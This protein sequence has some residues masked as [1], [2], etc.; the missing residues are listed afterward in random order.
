MLIGKNFS[1]PDQ[2]QERT[3]G[4]RIV[5]DIAD[6]LLAQDGDIS[7]L[8]DSIPTAVEYLWAHGRHE[9]RSG[10]ANATRNACNYLKPNGWSRT[11]TAPNTEIPAQLKAFGSYFT[12]ELL[13]SDLDAMT[14]EELVALVNANQAAVDACSCG[15]T[16]R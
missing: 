9:W 4:I 6:L 3:Y 15:A 12:E 2:P 13:K 11:E 7:K 10:F 16:T 8:P 14:S 5:R 1:Q